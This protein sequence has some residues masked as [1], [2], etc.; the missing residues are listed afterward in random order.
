M[1]MC[2]HTQVY[3]SSCFG[4]YQVGFTLAA[5]GVSSVVTCMVYGKLLKYIPRLVITQ[6]GVFLAILQS[7]FLLVWERTPS[8]TVIFTFSIGW[9]MI[10]AI[11]STS[12][13]KLI[14]YSFLKHSY[15]V[16]NHAMLIFISL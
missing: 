7:V 11:L 13:C 8:Y 6:F 3:I 10:E 14:P 4:T 12:A 9:G 1:Y 16:L 2:T 15:T 5:L